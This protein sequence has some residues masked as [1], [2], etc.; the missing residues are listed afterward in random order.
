M[1]ISLVTALTVVV[2]CSLGGVAPAQALGVGDLAKT[3]LGGSSV[4]KKGEEKCGQSIGMTK[5]DSLA[6]TYAR[7]AVEKVLP[8][9]Q[10]VAL[11]QA[12]ATDATT[13]AQSDSFC[14]DTAAKKPSMMKSIIKAGKSILKARALGTLGL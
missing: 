6:I 2:A 1:R 5:N 13:A 4:L 9:S 10:F 8:I 3:V 14:K 7:G 11:D 12:A